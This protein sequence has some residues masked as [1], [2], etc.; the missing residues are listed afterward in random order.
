MAARFQLTETAE[1]QIGDIVEFIAQDSE[2]AHADDHARKATRPPPRRGP[3]RW[4][5]LTRQHF[6]MDLEARVRK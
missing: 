6:R 5:E 1:D 4:W 2:E 3:S